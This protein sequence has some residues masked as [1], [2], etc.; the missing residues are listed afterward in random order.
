MTHPDGGSGT[1][2]GGGSGTGPKFRPPQQPTLISLLA[3]CV[4]MAVAEIAW[5]FARSPR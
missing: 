1:G 5:L 3:D 4:R 2:P